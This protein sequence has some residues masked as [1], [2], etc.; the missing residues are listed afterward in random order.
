[1]LISKEE[2]KKIKNLNKA[3]SL[4]KKGMELIKGNIKKEVDTDLYIYHN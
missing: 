4:I 2:L 3:Y 1:M